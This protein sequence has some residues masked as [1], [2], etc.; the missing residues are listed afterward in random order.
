MSASPAQYSINLD[1]TANVPVTE[2]IHQFQIVEFEEGESEKGPWIKF[3]CVCKDAGEE[4]KNPI[5]LFISLT[6][7]SRW[8]LELFLDALGAPKSG[9]VTA[10]RFVGKMFRGNVGHEDYQ[11][12]LQG[13]IG[14][15]FPVAASKTVA[16]SPAGTPVAKVKRTVKTNAAPAEA[17]APA[18]TQ[19]ELPTDVT[20]GA[21][22]IPF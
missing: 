21:D 14:E 11:G 5:N 17:P 8:R 19:P 15:M 7:Q 16:P 2:G 4:N 22:D 9:A 18:A 1:R 6:P 20:N 12:R 10:D 3:I 13:K